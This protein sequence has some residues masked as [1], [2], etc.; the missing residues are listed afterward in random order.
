MPK[1]GQKVVTSP[2]GMRLFGKLHHKHLDLISDLGAE[3]SQRV[4]GFACHKLILARLAQ[5]LTTY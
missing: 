3:T 1:D 4:E 2:F 5:G